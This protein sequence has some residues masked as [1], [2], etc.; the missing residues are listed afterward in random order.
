MTLPCH[1]SGSAAGTGQTQ[2][3][4][5]RRN[6]LHLIDRIRPDLRKNEE[7]LA[8]NADAFP[9]LFRICQMMVAPWMSASRSRQA[10]ENFS[11]RR[12]VFSL[13]FP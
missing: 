5:C 13:N 11:I 4:A 8:S 3:R 7:G 1:G 2:R 12:R 10:P 9:Y 6:T